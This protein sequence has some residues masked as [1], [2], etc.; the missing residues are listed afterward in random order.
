MV[1]PPCYRRV[2][3]RRDG[4]ALSLCFVEGASPAG[5]G[6]VAVLPTSAV[7]CSVQH[8]G[9]VRVRD[10]PFLTSDDPIQIQTQ[11][12]VGDLGEW[13]IDH[14]L[15]CRVVG[16]SPFNLTWPP[17]RLVWASRLQPARRQHSPDQLCISRRLRSS[18]RLSSQDFAYGVLPFPLINV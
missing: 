2:G 3:P 1:L 5:A 6:R 8:V 4:R 13:T 10:V 16:S 9:L 14:A 11:G 18:F 12:V 15:A 7:Q 17:R